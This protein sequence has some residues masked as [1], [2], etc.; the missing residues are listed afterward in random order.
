MID[1]GLW[2][3]YIL[4]FLALAGMAVYSIINMIGDFKKAKGTIIGVGILVGLFL[5][6]LLL[7]GNEVLPKY[8]QLGIAA[9]QSK[10]IGAGLIMMYILGI[11][12]VLIAIYAEVRKLFIK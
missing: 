9:G 1:V 10:M 4:F 6:S 8:E 2:I 11:G 12:T 5:V 3:S 7:S